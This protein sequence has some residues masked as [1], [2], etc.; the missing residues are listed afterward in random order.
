MGPPGSWGLTSSRGTELLEE[1]LAAGNTVISDITGPQN[2]LFPFLSPPFLSPPFFLRFSYIYSFHGCR[3][4]TSCPELA[5]SWEVSWFSHSAMLVL[6][7]H[8]F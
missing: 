3:S 1:G 2:C 8:M 6:G 4:E 7:G 5:G